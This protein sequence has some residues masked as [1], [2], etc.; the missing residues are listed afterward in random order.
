MAVKVTECGIENLM[1]VCTFMPTVTEDI[2]G[3]YDRAETRKWVAELIRLGFVRIQ[4]GE[5]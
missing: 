3:L 1:H 2:S 5:K 4:D